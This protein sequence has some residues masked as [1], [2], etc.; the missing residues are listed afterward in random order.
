MPVRYHGIEDY[1]EV[2]EREDIKVTLVVDQ[3][4]AGEYRASLMSEGQTLL[5]RQGNMFMCC[6]QDD[7]SDA[8]AALD[9]RASIC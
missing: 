9:V 3:T 2:H 5:D 6:I 4:D 1:I 8:I 7:I